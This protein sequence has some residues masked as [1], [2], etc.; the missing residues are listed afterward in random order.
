MDIHREYTAENHMYHT[1][2]GNWRVS[3]V[4]TITQICTLETLACSASPPPFWK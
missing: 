1:A 4:R 3:C 2:N